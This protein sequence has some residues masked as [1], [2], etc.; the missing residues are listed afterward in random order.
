MAVPVV[1]A[2]ARKGDIGVYFTGLGTW[3]ADS[4][5]L[6]LIIAPILAEYRA[7]RLA[8]LDHEELT[9]KTGAR[10][11]PWSSIEHMRIKGRTLTF[12]SNGL[13]TSATIETSDAARLG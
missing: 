13:W 12:K 3:V 1:A 5:I 8:N 2:K 11:I 9:S 4:V 6:A 7:H 10:T